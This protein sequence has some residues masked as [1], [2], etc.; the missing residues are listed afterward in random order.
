MIRNNLQIYIYS[1][2]ELLKQF[3]AEQH[4]D[5]KLLSFEIEEFRS[6]STVDH[7]R[8]IVRDEVDGVYIA[9]TYIAKP[10]KASV[11]FNSLSFYIDQLGSDSLFI[12][13][14]EFKPRY[15]TITGPELAIELTDKESNILYYLLTKKDFVSK[16]ELLTQIWGYKSDIDTK[17]VESH[18]YKLKQKVPFMR[19]AIKVLGSS[20]KIAYEELK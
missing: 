20:Y 12:G 13:E 19:D 17:T 6:Y 16:E 10:F 11:F 18:F 4:R 15:K 2:N 1:S 5:L 9:D 14:Y 8:L 3:I 7:L